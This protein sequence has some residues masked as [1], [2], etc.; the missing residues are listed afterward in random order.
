MGLESDVCRT[1]MMHLVPPSTPLSHYDCYQR[2]VQDY[3]EKMIVNFRGITNHHACWECTSDEGIYTLWDIL[4]SPH[5]THI[6]LRFLN[7]PRPKGLSNMFQVGT[8]ASRPREWSRRLLNFLTSQ[9]YSN[10]FWKKSRSYASDTEENITSRWIGNAKT[11]FHHKF[12]PPHRIIQSRGD[13][14]L[15]A[16]PQGENY[17]NYTYIAQNFISAVQ[18]KVLRCT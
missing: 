16:S 2:Y 8:E 14:K 5:C 12:L 15:S 1:Q 10:S 3:L 18:R 11:K 6:V 17:L 13:A 4:W 7:T 9:V